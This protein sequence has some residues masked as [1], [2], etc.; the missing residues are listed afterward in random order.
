MLNYLFIYGPLAASIILWGI[1]TAKL[2]KGLG[3]HKYRGIMT[4]AEVVKE[5]PSVSVC[6][7]ARNEVHAMVD[8]LERVIASSYPKLEII[9]LDDHSADDTPNLIKSFASAGV[10]FVE[11]DTLPMGWLGK[12]YS[13]Q[14]LAE[15]ASG[16]YILFIDVD[17]RLSPDSIEELVAYMTYEKVDMLSVLPRRDDGFRLSVI[18]STLRYFWEL[19]F[20]SKKT[21]S[22][23]SNAWMIRRELLMS[24]YEGFEHLKT[25]AQPE[26]VLASQ[27]MEKNTY[28]FLV[29]TP[30]IGVGY[31]KKWRSQVSTSV[32]LL[33]PLVGASIIKSFVASVALILL[34]SPLLVVIT[35]FFVGW[36]IEQITALVI[37]GSYNVMYGIYTSHVWRRGWLIGALLW[38]YIIVQE[39]FILLISIE[40][41]VRGAVIWRGRQIRLSRRSGTITQHSEG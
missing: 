17:T 10:R 1:M 41:H 11:G 30:F 32:R 14:R 16:T 20:H 22:S 28:R 25:S 40:R 21:P 24:T 7:P 2:I 18:F 9:V 26:T 23:S 36:N 12:N 37:I 19:I 39:A 34:S 3:R 29:G 6:I 13:L 4:N 33:Y 27:L 35:S 5:K 31:E 38:P 15:E 8:C